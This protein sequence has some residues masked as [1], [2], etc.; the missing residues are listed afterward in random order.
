MGTSTFAEYAVL[1]E[2]ALANVDKRASMDAICL[3]AC[4][5]TTGLAA[6]LW[7]AEVQPGSTIAVFGCGMVGL[8]ALVGA[9]LRGAERLIAVD[10][11]RERLALA[12]RFGATDVIVGGEGD[13]VQ[14]DPRPDRTASAPTTRSRPPD[15]ST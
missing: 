7:K 8:G 15:A 9:K 4:G 11:S 12:E 3:L 2:I 13:E 14:Q 5:A 10:L 6:A 1:P